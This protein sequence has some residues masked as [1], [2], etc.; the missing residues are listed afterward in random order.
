MNG[1]IV[2]ACG[3]LLSAA[4]SAAGIR[5]SPGTLAPMAFVSSGHRGAV[6][7]V[8]ED[9]ERGLLFS[10][11]E[12]GF[13]R[14][15]DTEAGTLVRKIAV[16]RQVAQSVA[17]NPSAPLAAVVVTDGLRSFAVDVWDWDAGKRLFS[18]PIVDAPLFVRFSWSGTYL[19]RR[20]HAVGQPSYLPIS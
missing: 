15:W 13:L 16:T 19:L 18:I 2:Q 11:G 17:L 5:V 14:I 6:M 12:D 4:L 10:V 1:L 8:A 20:G 7:D 9:S 3:L